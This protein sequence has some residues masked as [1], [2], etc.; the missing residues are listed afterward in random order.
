MVVSGTVD[1]KDRPGVAFTPRQVDLGPLGV[2]RLRRKLAD[3]PVEVTRVTVSIFGARHLLL[4]SGECWVDEQARRGPETRAELGSIILDRGVL[5]EMATLKSTGLLRQHGR[6][7]GHSVVYGTISANADVSG[8]A[9]IEEDA[10]LSG[11]VRVDRGVFKEGVYNRQSEVNRLLKELDRIVRRD[12]RPYR[13]GV[14][15]SDSTLTGSGNF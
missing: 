10:E 14:P 12:A 1:A 11:S 15:S 9:V 8:T 4:R 2:Y 7:H 3:Q 5:S 13:V 6:A